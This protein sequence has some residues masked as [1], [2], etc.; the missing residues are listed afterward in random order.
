MH[1]TILQPL[2][3]TVLQAVQKLLNYAHCNPDAEIL[4][5]ASDMILHTHSDAAYLVAPEA[6]LPAGGY[7]FLG[8]VDHTIFNGPIHV[9]AK[10]IKMSWHLPWRPK[11]RLCI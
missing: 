7:H 2:W 1:S 11:L 9:L 8:D 10:I 4:Y 5:R 3:L 6:R